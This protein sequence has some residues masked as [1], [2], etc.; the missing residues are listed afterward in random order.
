MQ[1]VKYLGLISRKRRL[2]VRKKFNILANIT[3]QILCCEIVSKDPLQ[4]KNNKCLKII[5][6][7]YVC[8]HLILYAP[9]QKL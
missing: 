8:D 6:F 5:H 3:R 7:V 4:A 9:C 1:K 2:Q